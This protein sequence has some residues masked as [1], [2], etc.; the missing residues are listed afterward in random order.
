MK[1]QITIFGATGMVGKRL[2]E[3]ATKRGYKVKIL[4][5]SI[6][7]LGWL[8]S[9][10]EI[11]EGN[12]FDHS[13]LKE[14]MEG[15][16]AILSTIGPPIKVKSKDV[17]E[18]KYHKSLKF[19]TETMPA[20]GVEKLISIAGAGIKYPGEKLSFSRKIIRL[21][22]KM[23]AKQLINVKDGELEIL[24][25]ST[26]NFVNIR[27]PMVKDIEGDLKVDA[28]N[29]VGMKVSLNQLC[30]FMLDNIDGNSWNRRFPIV[31]S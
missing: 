15:S 9:G 7:N 10:V 16:V 30:D 3:R 31:G 14:V 22:L 13:K 24:Y 27:P 1:N 18:T 6:E 21:M 25:N 12:Y 2:V 29:V 26:I 17:D 4:V 19:I 28:N 20:E 5:R 23:M 8:D 11:I